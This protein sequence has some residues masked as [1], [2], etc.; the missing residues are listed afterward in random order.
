MQAW[1]AEETS[2]K[3]YKKILLFK[4]F[5]LVVY[6]IYIYI[7]IYMYVCILYVVGS[8]DQKMPGPIFCPSPALIVIFKHEAVAFYN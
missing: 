2:L 4:N 1:W 6:I 8:L 7:Y 3:K 5:W